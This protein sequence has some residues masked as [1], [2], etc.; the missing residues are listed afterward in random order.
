LGVGEDEGDRE[1]RGDEGEIT[2]PPIHSSTHPPIHPFFI[3]SPAFPCRLEVREEEAQAVA[4][5]LPEESPG[6]RKTEPAG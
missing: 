4:G 6:F 1:D 5:I 3:L 2:H